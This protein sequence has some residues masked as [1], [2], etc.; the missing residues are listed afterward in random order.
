MLGLIRASGCSRGDKTGLILLVQ[1]EPALFD[2]LLE[3]EVLDVLRKRLQRD[4]RGASD[5]VTARAL[6]SASSL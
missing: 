5:C 6:L 4:T 3:G 2:G 1:E